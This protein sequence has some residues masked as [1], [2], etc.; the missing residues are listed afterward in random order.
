VLVGT[1]PAAGM[2]VPVGTPVMLMVSE[3]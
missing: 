1:Q 3:G 2:D